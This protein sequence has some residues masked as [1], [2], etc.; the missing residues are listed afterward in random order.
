MAGVNKAIIIGRLARDPEGK[1]LR[2]GD[3]VSNFT[4]VTSEEWK[5]KQTGEKKEKPEF[6]NCVAYR[7]LAGVINKYLKKGS[8]CFCEGRKET[9]AWTD[10]NDI[11]RYSVEIIVSS[12]QMLGD[13]QA[14]NKPPAQSAP[15]DNP[16]ENVF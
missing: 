9:R 16:D 2:S 1:V 6:H 8:Q 4:V 5:D 12:M 13:R 10:K 7:G 3:E 11:K 15:N 14:Q